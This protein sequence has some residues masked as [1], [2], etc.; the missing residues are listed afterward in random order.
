MGMSVNQP[1]GIVKRQ[2]LTED[3]FLGGKLSILQHRRGFRAGM[4]SVL[5]GASVP[6]DAGA[7]LDMGAGVGVAGLTALTHV[8]GARAMLAEIDPDQCALAMQNAAR[9]GLGG[10]TGVI[11][12]DVTAPGR[13]RLAAGL[14]RDHFDVVIANPPYFPAGTQSAVAGRARARHMAASAL[15]DWIR[16][17]ATAGH[18]QA[19][20]IMVYTAEAL[21]ALLAGFSARMGGIEILPI[22]ARPG[23][24]AGRVLVRGRKGSR[25]A[26]VLHAPLVIHEAEG[27]G[28]APVPEAIFRGARRL[29]WPKGG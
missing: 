24:A 28:F 15:E 27:N 8:P 18:A 20:I 19:E 13:E 6:D 25:A 22:A 7:I 29:D 14:V 2:D 11:A 12:V 16:A 1:L 4:D 3:A 17:A 10:R 21:P 9:N 23:R 26:P 5:L